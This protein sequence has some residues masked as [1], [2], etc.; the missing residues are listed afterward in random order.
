[1]PP[2]KT[3]QR[4]A[5]SVKGVVQGVGF[6]PFVY[7]MARRFGLTGW[8]TNTSGEVRI[9]VEG[10][11]EAVQAFRRSLEAEAPPQSRITSIMSTWLAP[12]G[13]DR[14]EIRDSLIEAGRYQLISPDLATCSDC[15]R[16]IY[17][18]EDRR[19]HYPFTNCTNC[20]P[21]FTIIEDIPYDRP[22]TTM[23]VFPICP[24]CRREY[25][26]PLDRRFHAQ[27]N[28]CPVCG[29]KLWLV[30]SSGRRVEAA[31]VIEKA[32]ELLRQGKIL[33]VR[34]LGGFLL[35]SDATSQTVVEELRRRKRRPAKPFAV[36]LSSLDEIEPRCELSV[37]ER[38]LLISAAA[39]IV[40]L[41]LNEGTDIASA[42]APGLKYLGVMLPYT[43]L[44]HLIMT[45]AGRPLVMTSGNLSEEP[46]ARDNDEALSRLGGIAD[47]FILHNREIFSRYDD[48]VVMH[49]ACEKRVLRRARGF[50]PYPV[51][52]TSAVP[53][54]LGVGAQE[55]NTFCLTR[56]DNAFVSQHIGDMENLE[57]IEHFEQTLSLYK[58]M[59][60]IEP[61]TITCDL[62]PDY[63]TSKWAAEE[64]A[65]LDIPL[66]KVQ[67]HHAHIASCLAENGV[68]GK[69]IGVALDGTGYGSDGKIWGGEFSVA[70]AAGIDRIAHLEYLP[71]PG[72]EAAVK[73]PYR[74]AAGY[75]YRLFGAEGLTQAAACLRCVDGSE[76]DLIKLQVD[77]GLNTPETSSAGRLF[78]AVSA[79]LGVRREIQ[80]DAQAAVELEMAADGVETGGSYPFDI[81]AEGGHRVIR[82]RRL[83]EGLLDD[84]HGGVRVPEMAARF[85]NAVVDIIV[86]VCE[87]IRGD[88]GLGSVALSGGCFMNRR[89]LR[90]SIER[91]GQAGFRVYAHR[92]VPTNDGGISL[93]QVAVA[94]HYVKNI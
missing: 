70:D 64:S 58:R 87:I 73:K 66:V 61:Q 85:H 16:E 55:K 4:L 68:S 7:Q 17:D 84:I 2:A 1:M 74:T 35:A 62:H 22:L 34:G 18:P 32:A 5:I 14:F 33:A 28:A 11:S 90:R 46:I 29:P 82:L 69:V 20:G 52:L 60:R 26:D 40:L 12:A 30:D 25:E 83:F 49:E 79:L 76:L 41:R 50:A 9:E 24:E 63:A 38:R 19:F 27:P 8:V 48:S 57:T 65:R 59:F 93:G 75:F 44:H 86:K 72:G 53:Q 91:L 10:S 37:E 77:R 42:V 80:Y 13:Y 67:H 94:A 54:I 15:R 51:R 39:P 78:D 71:L 56:D 89:L 92:E 6:R 3:S 81:A 47:Y 36:M 23:K 45:G 31:D 88:T 43:P 21:R